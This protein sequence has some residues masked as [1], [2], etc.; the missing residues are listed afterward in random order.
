MVNRL[1]RS[2]GVQVINVVRREAQVSLLKQQGASVILNSS[3]A[4][5]DQ[6]LY[7]VEYSKKSWG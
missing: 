5:F 2:K 1:G 3:E 4:D 7:D 6:Q